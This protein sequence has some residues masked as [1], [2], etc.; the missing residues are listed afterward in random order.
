M[1]TDARPIVRV[2]DIVKD[3]RPGFGLKR[4]RVLHGVTFDVQPG[5]IFGFVGPNGAGKT[6]MLKLLMGL[7]RPTSGRATILGHD[8]GESEFRQDVGFLP[9]NP[10]FYSFLTAR[11]ILDFYARLGGVPASERAQRVER[12]LGIVNR[13]VHAF[14]HVLEGF[15]EFFA[16]ANV[17]GSINSA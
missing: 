5:E 7:I 8:V 10:Y 11:E 1:T 2:Q 14:D 4:H 12:L 9:E 17:H 15:D 6:T 3:F 13:L 16:V